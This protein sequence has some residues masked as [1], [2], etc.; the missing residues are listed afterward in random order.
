LRMPLYAL[1]ASRIGNV[2]RDIDDGSDEN[3]SILTHQQYFGSLD[4]L[5]CS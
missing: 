3:L 2:H 4:L 1:F 5:S